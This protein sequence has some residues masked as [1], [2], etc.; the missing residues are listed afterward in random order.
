MIPCNLT[1]SLR[2]GGTWFVASVLL[3]CFWRRRRTGEG[4]KYIVPDFRH[5][6]GAGYLCQQHAATQPLIRVSLHLGRAWWSSKNEGSNQ[7]RE[8]LTTTS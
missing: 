6:A 2:T 7:G 4:D 8:V 5:V 1:V 3:E